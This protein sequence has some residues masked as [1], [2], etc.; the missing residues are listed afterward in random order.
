M[1]YLIFAFMLLSIVSC[2]KDETSQCLQ[3]TY[4]KSFIASVGKQ[5]C[6]DEKNYIVIDSVDNQLCPCGVTCIWEGEFILKM[7]V[8][9]DGK[10][11]IYDLHTYP[12]SI[13]IQPFDDYKI[14]FIAITP[15]ECDAFT[16]E[17]FKVELIL[18]KD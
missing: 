18:K 10:G 17:K 1:R 7:N 11:Y 5:Y 16:Q 6:I 2:S 14:G 3:I 9:A 12:N 8:F 15:D 4:N 13:Y